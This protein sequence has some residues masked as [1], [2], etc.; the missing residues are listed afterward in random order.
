MQ[1]RN[2]RTDQDFADEIQAHLALET[3]RLI[4]E[5]LNPGEARAAAR[6]AFGSRTR[7]HVQ[8]YESRRTMWLENARRDVTSALRTMVRNPGVS[9]LAM[10]TLALGVGANI[11][12]FSVIRGVLLQPP[13][14]ADAERL[15]MIWQTD[16]ATG[17]TREPASVPDYADIRARAT[18]LEATAAFMG[19]DVNVTPE[20]GDDPFRVA[21]LA[22]SQSFL[23]M[24]G[25]EP[26][27]GRSFSADED[28][29]GGAP[30][31]VI[32]ERLWEQR[33]GR[34][35][36]IARHRLR[37]N[38]VSHAIVGVMPHAADYGVLQVL[39]AAAYGRAFA[40][41]GRIG[42]DAWIPL[43]AD[44]A[45]ASRHNHPIFVMARLAPGVPTSAAR[46]ELTRIAS[47]LERAHPSTNDGRGV[48]VEPLDE[49]VLG[50]VRPALHVL[51]GAVVLV[52]VVAC[53]N[54]VSLLL[55]QSATR[56]REVAV[57]SALGASRGRLLAQFLAEGLV[58]SAGAV[59]LGAVV[60]WCMLRA[61]LALAPASLPRVSTIAI[62]LPV[63]LTAAM[64][65]LVIALGAA[66]VPALQ[67]RRLSVQ[68]TLKVEAGRTASGGRSRRRVLAAL[69]VAQVG[70]A[71][72]LVTG[73]GLIRSFW[74]LRAVAP[75]FRAEGVLKMEYQLP[76]SRYPRRIQD[77]PNWPEARGF[78]GELLRRA[79]ALP[80]VE[81]VAVASDH[82]V[83][84]GFTNSF[85]V[86][87]RE[88]EARTWPEIS[89]RSIS[90]DYA[91]VTGLA[92]I[93]GRHLRH[94]DTAEA[95]PVLLINNTARR[96]FFPTQDP[97][98]Q[99]IAFWGTRRT[100][101]GVV[102][103][104]KIHGLAKA[105]PPA[106]YVPYTQLPQADT[107]LVRVDGHPAQIAQS[108]RALIR[109]IDPG[110]A[111]FG[112][113]PLGQTVAASLGQERFTTLLLGLFAALTLALST[114][115]VYGVSSYGVSQRTS[116]IGV[117]L[118]LG[119]QRAGVVGLV[120]GQGMAL[121]V[122]GLAVGIIGAVVFSRL[123]T[124]L[125]FG[126]SSTDLLTFAIAPLILSVTGLIAS[127]V[128]A[129]RAAKVDPATALRSD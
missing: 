9:L 58:L 89:V 29:P 112:V 96:L 122:A 114:L 28:R 87:G 67:V 76:E 108:M 66:L 88:A 52:L 95:P 18:T 85:V 25:I 117:R 40:D 5:G 59:V 106:T 2:G 86:V 104:E 123:I 116:E 15:A 50:P 16:R 120:I 8:F 30:V 53:V 43:R 21:A 37:I 6:R 121:V 93:G 107:L 4:T 73:A 68:Q 23:P 33:F 55:V 27:V 24:L 54:V 63:L 22:V 91:R 47:E 39:S 51:V 61:L 111:V 128:P 83:A 71:V 48:F 94:A 81:A 72:V 31:V 113:E 82:P 124:T 90:A 129:W 118:A 13:P 46:G 75:G 115:G 17:T 42:V 38:D 62:D 70:L 3:D 105:T 65:G 101:V 10:L 45:T 79:A 97:V 7:S 80:G 36:D 84:A 34:D 44:P 11:A 1:P 41:R 20:K 100:I 110:L 74:H 19:A 99:Q 35:P 126:I 119:A 102:A 60:A 12:M 49:V 56:A 57:R 127:Y 64:L 26:V 92:L 32:G 98:G 78:Y 125:L 103:D 14:F 69:A 109:D 77:F